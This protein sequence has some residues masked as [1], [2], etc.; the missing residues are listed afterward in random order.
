MEPFGGALAL[1]AERVP[2]LEIVLPAVA[3]LRAE[4][5]AA[6]AN[7]PVKPA[8]VMGEEAKLAAFRRADAALAASGTV[9]LELALAGVPMA[10]AYRADRLVRLLKPL[11]IA[12]SIV[13]PNLI[14]GANVIPEFVNKN[15]QPGQLADAVVPL[16]SDTPA[17]RNQLE[18]FARLDRIMA[19]DG[20]AADLAACEVIATIARKRA[21]FAAA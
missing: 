10:V 3:R 12:P 11:L 14:L 2:G 21:P 4:I 5:D 16:L 6:V 20:L 1:I 18:A 9:T 15:S 13:L 17:R 19:T 7:W 8:I